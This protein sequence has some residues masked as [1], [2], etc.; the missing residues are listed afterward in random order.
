MK[1]KILIIGLVLLIILA[2]SIT[3][4]AITGRTQTAYDESEDTWE[5]FRD[6]MFE[7]KKAFIEERVK[8]GTLTQ[9]EADEILKNIELMQEYCL[10]VGGCGMGRGFGMMRNRLGNNS[11]YG[12]YGFRGMGFGGGRCGRGSW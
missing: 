3:V 5:K 8:D 4:F 2:T 11:G 12:N 6:E 10:G 1:N 9:E 7:N